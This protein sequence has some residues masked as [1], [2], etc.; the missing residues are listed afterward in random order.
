MTLDIS[1]Q[2]FCGL[3]AECPTRAVKMQVDWVAEY[4]AT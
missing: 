2:T 4:S 3:T 1:Q